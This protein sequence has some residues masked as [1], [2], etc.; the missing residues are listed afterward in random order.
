MKSTVSRTP[1]LT[2]LAGLALFVHAGCG[3][4]PTADEVTSGGAGG[5]QTIT[6]HVPEMTGRLKLL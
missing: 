1:R 3:N 2:V 4:S 5:P 6:F